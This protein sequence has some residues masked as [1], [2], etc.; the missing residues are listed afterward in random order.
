M[1]VTKGGKYVVMFILSHTAAKAD[2]HQNVNC[3]V[4][5]L[6]NFNKSQLC[7]FY[8]VSIVSARPLPD[9]IDSTFFFCFC[10]ISSPE[11]NSE[12]SSV[13][14]QLSSNSGSRIDKLRPNSLGH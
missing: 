5:E 7:F 2:H 11:S 3:W 14:Q 13:L 6:N 9:E 4:I 10:I 1:T 12:H 8:L